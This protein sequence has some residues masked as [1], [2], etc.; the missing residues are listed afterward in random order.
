[1]ASAMRHIL[2]V[3]TCLAVRYN[4]VIRKV[5][6]YIKLITFSCLVHGLIIMILLVAKSIHV[7]LAIY[8]QHFK[9]V[10]CGKPFLV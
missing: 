1:M 2:D 4:K 7:D 9:I 3:L 8:L 6:H 10:L 5:S